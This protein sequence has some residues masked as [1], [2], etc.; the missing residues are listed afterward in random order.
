MG[1]NGVAKVQT[2]HHSIVS[3]ARAPGLFVPGGAGNSV[4]H[5]RGELC[6]HLG[7]GWSATGVAS[8]HR[9][10]TTGGDNSDAEAASR[11]HVATA[12]RTQRASGQTGAM[13]V[14]R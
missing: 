4:K 2:R 7:R 14:R 10:T 3:A 11:H 1:D 13:D 12:A 8:A 5:V 6:L 9:V